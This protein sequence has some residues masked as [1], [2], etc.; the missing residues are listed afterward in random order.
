M[1]IA[2]AGNIGSG[3]TTLTSLLSKHY[4][5]DS[6]KIINQLKEIVEN[7]PKESFTFEELRQISAGFFAIDQTLV[8]QVNH[9][10]FP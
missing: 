1:Q 6:N 8:F 4:E 9:N 2:V 5:W 10:Q 7:N 3:K